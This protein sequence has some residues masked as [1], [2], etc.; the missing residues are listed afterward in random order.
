MIL[1]TNGSQTE[2]AFALY[3]FQYKEESVATSTYIIVQLS[4]MPS[5]FALL[6]GSKREPLE[7]GWTS[8][9]KCHVTSVT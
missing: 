5:H 3:S 9:L 1:K 8:I 6:P 2:G 7:R 4:L